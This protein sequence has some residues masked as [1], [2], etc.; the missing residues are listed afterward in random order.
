MRNVFFVTDCTRSGNKAIDLMLKLHQTL[1]F[2]LFNQQKMWAFLFAS[3]LFFSLV[4]MGR[5][6]LKKASLFF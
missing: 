2:I 1:E 6:A 3:A 4:L 5:D